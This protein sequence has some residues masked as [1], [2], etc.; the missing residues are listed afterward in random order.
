MRY[1]TSTSAIATAAIAL[2]AGVGTSALGGV[3]GD[4]PDV[5]VC[6][7][8]DPTQV[9]PWDQLV[10]YVSARIEDGATLYKSL[11]S[12]PVL[13]TVGLD[14]SVQAPNLEDCDGKTV[15]ALRRAGRARDYGG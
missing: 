9:L 1:R 13:V 3:F 8:D 7:V 11:T 14:G 5:I 10:F 4:P 2:L 15:A 6:S 12:N